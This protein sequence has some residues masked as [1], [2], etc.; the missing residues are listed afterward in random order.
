MRR[1]IGTSLLHGACCSTAVL[2]GD[3]KIRAHGTGNENESCRKGCQKTETL[4]H[5][6]LECPH[7]ANCRSKCIREA[8]RWNIPFDVTHAMC[9][10]KLHLFTEKFF[11]KLHDK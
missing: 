4:N 6:L 8:R 10:P 5:I 11:C 3:L 1:K 2:R 7:Y 9:H